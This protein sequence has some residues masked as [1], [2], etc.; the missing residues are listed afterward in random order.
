ML[1]LILPACGLINIQVRHSGSVGKQKNERSSEKASR[2]AK[3]NDQTAGKHNASAKK[4]KNRN[5]RAPQPAAAPATAGRTQQRPSRTAVQRQQTRPGIDVSWSKELPSVQKVDSAVGNDIYRKWASYEVLLG[6]TSNRI[7]AAVGSAP[8]SRSNVFQFANRRQNEY[9][10]AQK[11]L[12]KAGDKP[13]ASVAKGARVYTDSH[14]FYAD[15]IEALVS[16]DA[17]EWFKKRN[18]W[19]QSRIAEEARQKREEAEREHRQQMEKKAIVMRQRLVADLIA[20]VNRNVFGIEL[21]EQLHLPSCMLQSGETEIIS[22]IFGAGV[23]GPVTCIG[24]PYGI[25]P[26]KDI[27]DAEVKEL[28]NMPADV[29]QKI[30]KV[31]LA[32]AVCPDWMRASTTCYIKLMVG[33]DFVL[34]AEVYVSVE[35]QYYTAAMNYLI[36]RY[37]ESYS[38]T[39]AGISLACLH[40]RK[41]HV[42]KKPGLTVSYDPLGVVQCA[43]GI[44]TFK[45]DT[46]SEAQ[47]GP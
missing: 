35:P 2:S 18:A 20:G 4:S 43:G 37:G 10:A 33:F 28:M 21:G 47:I 46:L 13:S 6:Y 9:Q 1:C 5:Q 39:P 42:W 8:F 38:T 17:A 44:I 24:T 30:V 16:K 19:Y 3:T 22:G 34:G 40:T 14:I 26:P 15:T 32:D 41:M 11:A 25:K 12:Q 7:L 27:A 45:L 29:E 31:R 36:E 23:G